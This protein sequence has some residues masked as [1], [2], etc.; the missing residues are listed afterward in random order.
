MM[1]KK[2]TIAIQAIL[3]VMMFIYGVS[4]RLEVEVLASENTA[5]Q[6]KLEQCNR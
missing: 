3:I 5:L 1:T 4:K 2:L 6:Q